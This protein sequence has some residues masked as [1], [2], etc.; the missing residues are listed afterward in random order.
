[1]QDRP[2]DVSV[3]PPGA[4]PVGVV[5]ECDANSRTR[6]LCRAHLGLVGSRRSSLRF[7]FAAGQLPANLLSGTPRLGVRWR[8]QA[9]RRAGMDPESDHVGQVTEGSPQ[10]T[11]RRFRMERDTTMSPSTGQVRSEFHAKRGFAP[12]SAL[13]MQ[14]I[15]KEQLTSIARFPLPIPFPISIWTQSHVAGLSERTADGWMTGARHSLRCRLG[16]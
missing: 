3:G 4:Y 14:P 11:D 6:V 13:K 5:A 7:D 12:N 16:V 1:M 9:H 2:G 15:C 8:F 10:E